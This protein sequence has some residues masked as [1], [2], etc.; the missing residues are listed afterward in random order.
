MVQIFIV[1]VREAH[2]IDSRRPVKYAK[3]LGIKNHTSYEER[4]SV[5]NR[6]V[7]DKEMAVPILVDEIDNTVNKLY[8]ASPTRVFLVRK[9]GKLGVAGS[10]GPWGLKPALKEAK[11]W[12]KKFKETGNEPPITTAEED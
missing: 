6:F 2:A 12:L 11:D 9:D 1:Y 7:R 3:E 8:S 4:C 10:R 5:A